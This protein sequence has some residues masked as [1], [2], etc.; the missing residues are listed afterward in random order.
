M[1]TFGDWKAREAGVPEAFRVAHSLSLP[2]HGLEG[3]RLVVDGFPPIGFGFRI[4]RL[5]HNRQRGKRGER[6]EVA[7]FHDCRQ[8]NRAAAV[9]KEKFGKRG[10]RL[11]PGASPGGGEHG[12]ARGYVFVDPVWH[13]G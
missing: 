8:T 9:E 2:G 7:A 11:F 5:S 10:L 1:R 3:Q 4:S 13:G 6:E 12:L